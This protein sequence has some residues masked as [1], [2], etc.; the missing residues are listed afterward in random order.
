MEYKHSRANKVQT[1]GWRDRKAAM[2]EVLEG[3]ERAKA[4]KKF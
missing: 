1:K 2:T 3:I 4:A